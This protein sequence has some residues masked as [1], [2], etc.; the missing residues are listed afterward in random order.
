[1]SDTS[2]DDHGA[3]KD[4]PKVSFIESWRWGIV[5]ACAL[6]LIIAI[7]IHY[8]KS[9]TSDESQVQTREQS[10]G[11]T[12]RPTRDNPIRKLLTNEWTEITQYSQVTG[13]WKIQ[14]G[15]TEIELT[16]DPYDTS[17]YWKPATISK[18]L[19]AGHTVYGRTVQDEAEQRIAFFYE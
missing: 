19:K 11:V 3:K 12:G 15:D 4:A 7:I 10:S 14:W 2:S 17:K 16:T 6:F 1:M 5:G 9:E 13:D 8:K 18:N